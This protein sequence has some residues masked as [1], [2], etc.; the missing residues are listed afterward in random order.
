M[1]QHLRCMVLL[2]LHFRRQVEQTLLR[3][4]V[5][6]PKTERK[7]RTLKRKNKHLKH[8]PY[9]HLGISLL[10]INIIPIMKNRFYPLLEYN[11]NTIFFYW[12]LLP[13]KGKKKNLHINLIFCYTNC[14]FDICVYLIFW[15]LFITHKNNV[16]CIWNCSCPFCTFF[17]LKMKHVDTQST[18]SHSCLA[19][20]FRRM[21][22][23]GTDVQ[24]DCTDMHFSWGPMP[25]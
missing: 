6:T 14:T 21:C 7:T 15:T 22:V 25:K 4:L 24:A 1:T 20:T 8:V 16:R 2:I 17:T 5:S 9:P 23:E 3:T 18:E 13:Q 10:K 12:L 19:Y 11:W